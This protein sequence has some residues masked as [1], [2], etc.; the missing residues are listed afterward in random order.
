MQN[1]KPNRGA[2]A[3]SAAAGNLSFGGARKCK[4][5]ALASFEKQFGGASDNFFLGRWLART[6][7]GDEIINAERD[8]ETIEPWAEIRSA[9]WDA[10]RDAFYAICHVERA[11]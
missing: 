11:T 5:A 10:N 6:T 4:R 1:T 3:K 9:R 2:A 8:A 7:D